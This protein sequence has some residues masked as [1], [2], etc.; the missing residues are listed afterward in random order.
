VISLELA[1][2][3]K[4]FGQVT[5]VDG[6]SL[7][8]EQGEFLSLLGPS[9]CGKTT[10]LRLIAG[11]EQVDEGDILIRG[12]STRGVPPY[13]RNVGMV[14]QNYALFPHLSVAENIA[15]GLRERRVAREAIRRKV[16]ESLALVRLG[17]LGA[18][19]P[20]ELS[21]GQQQ[22]VALARALVIEP[23]L[24]LLDEPL[25]NLDA[26]L[27][28][29]MRVEIKE[30]QAKLG[31]TTVFVTHDQIEAL[32]LATRVVIMRNGGAAQIGVPAEIYQRPRARFA[33][34][35]LGGTNIFQGRLLDGATE[36]VFE[37][38][39]GL[40]LQ[41]RGTVATPGAVRYVGVRP[42]DITV[43]A[44]DAPG[45]PNTFPARIRSVLYR[46]WTREVVLTLDRGETIKAVELLPRGAQTALP[47][48]GTVNV[49]WPPDA[50]HFLE[51][52]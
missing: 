30:L 45:G 13:R 9:G 20:S 18:R 51:E 29:E 47:A 28:E 38:A 16:E 33:F 1:N 44:S 5:A 27:R 41:G 21:G 22:R 11:Y 10:A 39:S 17:N 15:F 6:L 36:S 3:V 43:H 32:T 24:L 52:D 12:R 7:Q 42:E 49:M 50:C 48:D 23:E 19:Y 35:F 40:R 14:F 25:S 31:I 8:V 34:E 4:R 37:T 2:V 26:Q 46:G